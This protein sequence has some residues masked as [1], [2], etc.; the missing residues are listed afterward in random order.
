MASLVAVLAAT[1]RRSDGGVRRPRRGHR[2][3]PPRSRRSRRRR[4][5]CSARGSASCPG[6]PCPPPSAAEWGTGARRPGRA[7]RPSR[8]QPAGDFPVEDWMHSAARVREPRAPPRAGRAAGAGARRR[9]P[10]AHTRPA[11]V[12]A[13]RCVARDGV[14]ADPGSRRRAPPVFGRCTRPASIRRATSAGCSWMP[15]PRCCPSD[16]TTVGL[17]FHYDQPSSEAPQS[18]LLVTPATEGKT[19]TWDDLRQA[20]PDTMRLARQRAVEP[21]HLDDRAPSRDSCP[22][23][24]PRS[25]RAASRSG[26]S[27]AVS[28]LVHLDPGGR[29]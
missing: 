7:A 17:A 14:P 20:I 18:L 3:R 16:D 23:R 27:Y 29:R 28:N 2:T 5:R 21:V 12:P 22:R 9:R 25:P 15:G 10:G 6:S 19:W 4:R 26:S 1:G 8:P 24:S 13:G 11:P